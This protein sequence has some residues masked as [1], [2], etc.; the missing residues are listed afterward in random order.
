MSKYASIGG[1]KPI[2][3]YDDEQLENKQDARFD[4]E[5]PHIYVNGTIGYFS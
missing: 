3:Y 5:L 2:T 4:P 1:I